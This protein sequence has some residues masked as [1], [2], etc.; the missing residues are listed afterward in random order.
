MP[1]RVPSA[2]WLHE[3]CL[4]AL[5]YI[6]A[7]RRLEDVNR[8]LAGCVDRPS[9]ERSRLFDEQ[10]VAL[11]AQAAARPRLES[12]LDESGGMAPYGWPESVSGTLGKITLMLR[13]GYGYVCYE[14]GGISGL[15]EEIES[16]AAADRGGGDGFIP[17]REALAITN[18]TSSELSKAS[19][20]GRPIRSIG[21]RKG[22]LVHELDARRYADELKS[23][24]R[25]RGR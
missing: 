2:E 23:R 21:K 1:N 4:R 6:H 14:W 11:E 13:L 8:R 16:L 24:R 3:I 25:D 5:A 19:G 9:A 20:P 12:S 18:L 22:K 17:F 10:M 15:E 7:C